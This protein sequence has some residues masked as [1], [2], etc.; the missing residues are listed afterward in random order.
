MRKSGSVEK[1]CS[2]SAWALNLLASAVVRPTPG[3]EENW[4]LRKDSLAPVVTSWTAGSEPKGMRKSGSV[5][6]SA[7]TPRRPDLLASS[8]AD[9]SPRRIRKSGSV[10]KK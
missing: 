8:P 7:A 1:K 9:L 4:F 3:H 2:D 10:E 5:E 6:K